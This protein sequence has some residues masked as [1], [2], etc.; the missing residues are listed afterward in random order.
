[1][2]YKE[3]V[4]MSAPTISC[5][6]GFTTRFGGV[7]EGVFESLNLGENRGD[8]PENVCENYRRLLEALEIPEQDLCYTKQVHGSEVRIVSD[9]DR[10]ERFSTFVYEADGLVTNVKYLP[11]ICYTADCVP[12][13]LCDAEAEV[14]AAVHCGWRSTVSDILGEAVRKM[15]SLGALPNYI[16]A[17]IGP[18]IDMCCFETGEEVPKAIDRLLAEDSE[19]T[20]FELGDTGKFM[21]DLKETLRRRLLALEVKDENISISDECT[22]CHSNK[23]WSH[24]ATNGERG[25]QAALIML[26]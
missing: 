14:I 23:Y 15:I 2:S 10:R 11:L 25:S 24:R 17:A 20:Y 16:C 4:F 22:S 21:V 13:L 19:G 26:G 12:V 8:D 6:H 7:S 5:K 18:A 1:M 9:E 3:L